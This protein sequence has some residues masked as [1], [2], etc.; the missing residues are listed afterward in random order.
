MQQFRLFSTKPPQLK[1]L[2]KRPSLKLWG[3]FLAFSV[4]LLFSC[5]SSTTSGLSSS[6]SKSIQFATENFE[7]IFDKAAEKKMPIFIDFYASW[8]APCKKMDKEVFTDPKVRGLFNESYLSLKVNG[9]TGEGKKLAKN[10]QVRGYP[11]LLFLNAKGEIIN[12]ILGYANTQTL[13][14]YGRKSLKEHENSAFFSSSSTPMKKSIN[15]KRLRSLLESYVFSQHIGTLESYRLDE[16]EKAEWIDES[17]EI[18]KVT[19]R[20]KVDTN[21]KKIGEPTERFYKETVIVTNYFGIRK[22]EN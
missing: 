17:E 3:F 21:A 6:K 9:E 11:T 18:I 10:Y 12:R 16:V 7:D 15:Q 14:T 2:S 20:V 22:T 8:C 1:Q 13:L 5:S 4:C 19:Y